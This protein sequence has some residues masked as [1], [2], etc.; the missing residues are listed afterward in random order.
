MSTTINP[1]IDGVSDVAYNQDANGNVIG[2]PNPSSNGGILDTFPH[3]PSPVA[4]KCNRIVRGGNNFYSF[5]DHTVL[6]NTGTENANYVLSTVSGV[7]GIAYDNSG[8][9]TGSPTMVK[10]AVS[11]QAGAANNFIASPNNLALTMVD[12]KFGFW[13]YYSPDSTWAVPNLHIRL[14]ATNVPNGTTDWDF[15]M[16][17]NQ[18][19][20]G[21]NFL[22]VI[23]LNAT[24]PYGITAVNGSESFAAGATTLNK[25]DFYL[26]VTA[27]QTCTLYFDTAWNNFYTKPAVMLGLDGVNAATLPTYSIPI[28]AKYGFRGYMMN[29]AQATNDNSIWKDFTTRHANTDL[30]YAAGWD[31][32]NHTLNHTTTSTGT[33]PLATSLLTAAQLQYL[34]TAQTSYQLAMGWDRGKEFYGAPTGSWDNT[35]V[36]LIK[37]AGYTMQRNSSVS[38][39]NNTRTQW[40]YDQPQNMGWISLDNP[41]QGLTGAYLSN[42]EAN[43]QPLLDYGGDVWIGWHDVVAG[44]GNMSAYTNSVTQIYHDQLDALCAWLA[45]LQAAGTI[46]VMTPTECAYNL[47]S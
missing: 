4:Q 36:A 34:L 22:V 14:A 46:S 24:H 13:V 47:K 25:F 32:C 12:N 10:L 30:A 3:R 31:I 23:P 7:N 37:M 8:S 17:I 43:I 16:N 28:M 40:G 39:Q 44:S 45:G 19:R 21:W 29:S 27:G 18:M 6:L 35:N 11:G 33:P 15:S 41:T 42:W 1:S 26:K 2:F 9:Q 5:T 38:H 20:P